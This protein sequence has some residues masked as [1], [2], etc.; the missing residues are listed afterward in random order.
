MLASLGN[1]DAAEVAKRL[2]DVAEEAA[3]AARAARETE[4]RQDGL[5]RL[6]AALRTIDKGAGRLETLAVLGHD[7]GGVT[8]ADAGRAQ[9]ARDAGDLTHTELAAL[10]LAARLRRP[11]PSFGATTG[12]GRGGGVESGHGRGAGAGEGGLP[13][14]SSADEAFDRIANEIAE[15]AEQ[16]GSTVRGAEA[17]LDEARRAQQADADKKEAKRLAD[18]IRTAVDELP[19]PGQEFGTPRAAAALA[20]EHARAAAHALDDLALKEAADSAESA[21]G[22][23]DQA[24]RRFDP[25][26]GL[27][28]HFDEARRALREALDFSRREI[29]RERQAADARARSS[30]EQ[31]GDTERDLAEQATKLA[32][33]PDGREAALPRETAERLGRAGSVMREAARELAAGHGE[34]GVDLGHEAER[35]LEQSRPGRSSDAEPEQEKEQPPERAG[36]SRSRSPERGPSGQSIAIGGDVPGPDKGAR[37]EEFRRRVLEGLASEKSERLSGAVKRYAEG[38]LR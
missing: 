15:L 14:P 1:R 16:H 25:E 7:L 18:K 19:L 5:S 31:A 4:H 26:D 38:L 8:R 2:A 20:R 24:E 33:D 30:L 22:T 3:M 27:H 10:H 6:D 28:P 11:V 34:R 35:L 17:A 37:A 36:E 9:R 32:G 21:L 29:A 13:P 23:L 12:G